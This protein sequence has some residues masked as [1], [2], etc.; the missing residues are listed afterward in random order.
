MKIA[1]GVS[2]ED[3]NYLWKLLNEQWGQKLNDN[4][5]LLL[6]VS[7]RAL[8]PF[9]E[10]VKLFLEEKQLKGEIGFWCYLKYENDQEEVSIYIQPYFCPSKICHW[11]T[12]GNHFKISFPAFFVKGKVMLSG[13]VLKYQTSYIITQF[14]C[15]RIIKDGLSEGMK[16][17][18]NQL[19][20]LLSLHDSSITSNFFIEQ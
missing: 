11:F 3:G 10:K 14:L 2:K 18:I 17:S 4:L 8:K 9:E 15:F 1:F 6:R 20:I 7:V 16:Y 13:D 19:K 5:D 12:L